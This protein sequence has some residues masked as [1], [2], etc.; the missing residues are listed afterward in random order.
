MG[1]M[2]NFLGSSRG[3]GGNAGRSSDFGQ[4]VS[5]SSG[6]SSQQGGG[7]TIVP[8]SPSSSLV[9]ASLMSKT[10]TTSSGLG[11]DMWSTGSQGGS[12]G[13]NLFNSSGSVWGAPEGSRTTTPLNSFLPGDLLGES[14]NP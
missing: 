8:S 13:P 2:N 7:G 1:G 5:S 3:S 9:G 14:G 11:N 6:T 4:A 12:A 10:V